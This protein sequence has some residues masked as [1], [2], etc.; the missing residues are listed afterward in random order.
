MIQRWVSFA[1]IK[2]IQF[3]CQGW[4]EN[5]PRKE[6]DDDDERKDLETLLIYPLN[7]YRLVWHEKESKVIHF[8]WE[9]K[10]GKKISC[11]GEKNYLHQRPSLT[12]RIK[13]KRIAIQWHQ[14]IYKGEESHTRKLKKQGIPCLLFTFFSLSLNPES[15]FY[16][17]QEG[18]KLLRVIP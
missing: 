7:P 11:K 4:S 14:N 3:E 16:S 10:R 18:N 17:C 1:V 8:P 13:K 5:D 2:V 6:D 12:D 15:C 9:F